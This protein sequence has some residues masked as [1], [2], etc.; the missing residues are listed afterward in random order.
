MYALAIAVLLQLGLFEG[1]GRARDD[2][3]KCLVCGDQ[4]VGRSEIELHIRAHFLDEPDVGET[5]SG[6][7]SPGRATRDRVVRSDID[8]Q[9]DVDSAPYQAG[10]TATPQIGAAGDMESLVSQISSNPALAKMLSDALEQVARNEREA[11][12]PLEE[13]PSPELESLTLDQ[14]TLRRSAELH[15]L[16]DAG[17]GDDAAQDDDVI[18]LPPPVISDDAAPSAWIVADD[19]DAQVPPERRDLT[20]PS[21][22]ELAESRKRREAFERLKAQAAEHQPEP[23]SEPESFDPS[24]LPVEPPPI[25]V[26]EEDA[27]AGG[28]APADIEA[29]IRRAAFR[30]V[31]DEKADDPTDDPQGPDSKA[32]QQRQELESILGESIAAAPDAPG[33]GSDTPNAGTDDPPDDTTSI[34][35]ERRAEFERFRLGMDAGAQETVS[36]YAAEDANDEVELPGGVW[37]AGP[38]EDPESEDWHNAFERL[39]SE[40]EKPDDLEAPEGTAEPEPSDPSGV[41]PGD[42]PNDSSPVPEEDDLDLGSW[43]DAFQKLTAERGTA[44]VEQDAPSQEEPPAGEN[45]EGLTT[46]FESETLDEGVG[47]EI[48]TTEVDDD[49]TS[50][51]PVDVGSSDEG[52]AR[53]E[54]FA[55]LQQQASEPD[56]SPPSSESALRMA[57]FERLRREVLEVGPPA[58]PTPPEPTDMP[59]D[60]AMLGGDEQPDE[61]AAVAEASLDV[62]ELDASSDMVSPAEMEEVDGEE[63]GNGARRSFSLDSLGGRVSLASWGMKGR[64]LIS[65]ISTSKPQ[66][67]TS[68]T[69]EH[70]FIKL[71]V[72]R[73]MD[74]LDYRIVPANPVLFR[75][76][77]ISDAS[78]MAALLKRALQDLDGDH[79]RVLAAVPG[80]QTN[81]RRLELPNVRKM[82]PSVAIPSEARRTMG[83]SPESSHLSWRPLPGAADSSNW[84][85]VSATNRSVSSISA[86]ADGAGLSMKAVELRPFAVARAT[87]QPDAVFAWTAADGCDA[88]VVRDWV[89]LTYQSAYWGAGS[90]VQPPDLVNRITE[91]VESTIAAHDVEAPELSVSKDMPLFVYGSPTGRDETVGVRVAQN[92]GMATQEPD[93]PLNVP[94]GFPV[95]ELIV[96]IGLS[97]WED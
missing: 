34:A 95:R 32:E 80:Y 8:E 30:W 48:G 49:A 31:Q 20:E 62:A 46:A 79:R 24:A 43:H 42:E 44:D 67:T 9:K 87:N 45:D 81:L 60:D 5:P 25:Q 35:D 18:A 6:A 54:E 27:P 78:R 92:V 86:M 91:V 26:P 63:Q 70:G 76:G 36:P 21:P 59:D 17:L 41:T 96:N 19:E 23:V 39:A 10:P 4:I 22:D 90:E 1:V 75:E 93:V 16:G 47:T 2:E 82:D 56:E 28:L 66:E 68:I 74:V 51:F 64:E 7:A 57:E 55:R 73:G 13:V 15:D 38:A 71:L 65:R 29:E 52:A 72:T 85:V 11:A 14:A 69:V 37:P 83:V 50:T 97:L 77:M 12:P 33:I 53:R 61:G 89:P 58:A 94:D 88:V 40:R 84:L 3:Y